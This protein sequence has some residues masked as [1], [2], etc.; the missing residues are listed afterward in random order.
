MTEFINEILKISYFIFLSFC[1]AFILL[2]VVYLLSF[3]SKIDYEKSSAYECGFTP[4]SETNYPFEISFALVAILFLLFDIEILYLYPICTSI[5][6]FTSIEILYLVGFFIIVA[7]GLVYEISKNIVHFFDYSSRDIT[8]T[9]YYVNFHYEKSFNNRY[10]NIP[11]FRSIYDNSNNF[12]K[13]NY[14]T[15]RSIMKVSDHSLINKLYRNILKY[16]FIWILFI[17]SFFITEK[18][19][20]ICIFLMPI[21]NLIFV[22]LSNLYPMVITQFTCMYFF[23]YFGTQVIVYDFLGSKITDHI[24]SN[25]DPILLFT[26]LLIS[27]YAMYLEVLLLH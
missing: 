15:N 10:H 12:Q 11:R 21:M 3:T 14:H 20:R 4:F 16:L 9:N 1:L 5:L 18:S 2:I 23:M 6:S 13:R 26:T 17:R 8:N 27:L 7:L 24:L 19:Y 22:I 25:T